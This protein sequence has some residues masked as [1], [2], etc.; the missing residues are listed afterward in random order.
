MMQL[1]IYLRYM[2]L[3]LITPLL[4]LLLTVILS[5][6]CLW[7]DLGLPSIIDLYILTEKFI[8]EDSFKKYNLY[9]FLE[10]RSFIGTVEGLDPY[11]LIVIRE[12]YCNLSPHFA[13]LD[14]PKL[15]KAYL[16][17]FVYEFTPVKIN[18]FFGTSNFEETH[19]KKS[20]L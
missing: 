1:M 8:V 7:W 19:Y 11:V 15:G 17:G 2:Y 16:R 14:S 12:F 9:E 5:I 4:M 3:P 18:D 6:I 20:G 10:Q 13:D